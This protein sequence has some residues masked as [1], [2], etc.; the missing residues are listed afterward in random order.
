MSLAWR[1]TPEQTGIGFD[2]LDELSEIIDA[3]GREGRYRLFPGAENGE[4]AV[5]GEHVDRERVQP[6]F[7]FAKHFGGVGDGEDAG[8]GSQGQAAWLAHARRGRQFQGKSSSSLW[9]GG[10]AMRAKTAAATG[11]GA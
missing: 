2:H 11:C 3:V 7:I 4:A 9:A 1:I 8:D 6:V 5:F 10:S